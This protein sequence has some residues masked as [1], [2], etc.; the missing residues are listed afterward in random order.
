VGIV[1]Q[2]DLMAKTPTLK[3]AR[4]MKSVSKKTRR[5]PATAL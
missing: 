2:A 1:S 4:A 3:V 5:Q